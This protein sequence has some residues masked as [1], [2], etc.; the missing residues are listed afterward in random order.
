[1]AK[2]ACGYRVNDPAQLAGAPLSALEN[3]RKG[4]R[5]AGLPAT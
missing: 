1:M 4:L 3:L 2:Q 5:L